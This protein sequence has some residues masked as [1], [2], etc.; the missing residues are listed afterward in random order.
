MAVAA[1]QGADQQ[2]LVIPRA[3]NVHCLAKKKKKKKR[4]HTLT[5]SWAG[6]PLALITACICCGIVSISFCNVTR[7]M[8]SVALIFR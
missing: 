4:S 5:F 1:M 2:L 8:S 3:T 7:F 6:P